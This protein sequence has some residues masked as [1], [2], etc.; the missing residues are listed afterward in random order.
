MHVSNRFWTARAL[1]LRVTMIAPYF[2][3]SHQ[4]ERNARIHHNG[5]E[6]SMFRSSAVEKVGRGFSRPVKTQSFITAVLFDLH[7][8]A[9]LLFNCRAPTSNT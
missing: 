4:L 6:Y 2:G 5:L 8:S 7:R 9:E 3:C 1:M